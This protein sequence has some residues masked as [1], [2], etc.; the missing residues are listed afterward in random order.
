MVCL[1]PERN[2][3]DLN[4]PIQCARHPAQHCQGVAFVIGILQPADFRRGRADELGKLY[5]GGSRLGPQIVNFT[6]YFFAR[7]RFFKVFQP[8]RLSFTK[9]TV[10]DLHP[11][12]DG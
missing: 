2:E 4:S 7:S 6:G 3:P 8:D 5:L 1:P 10:R 12:D 9:L 11:V